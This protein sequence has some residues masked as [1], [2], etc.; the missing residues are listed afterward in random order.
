VDVLVLH[1]RQVDPPDVAMHP[2]HR[3]QA[4]RQVKVRC[5]VLDRESDQL[6]NVHL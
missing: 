3:R 4:R 1:R 2:D 6:G 5:L